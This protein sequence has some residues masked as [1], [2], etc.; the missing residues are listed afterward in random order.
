MTKS[1]S[2]NMDELGPRGRTSLFR[3]TTEL[4]GTD[5]VTNALPATME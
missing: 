4:A 2:S 3:V 1:R 5:V